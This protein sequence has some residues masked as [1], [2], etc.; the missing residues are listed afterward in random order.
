[1]SRNTK[2]R[3]HSLSASKIF[4]S[5]GG[6]AAL[7]LML[8]NPANAVGGRV[9]DVGSSERINLSGQLATL[10][11]R[12]IASACNISA[13]VAVAESSAVLAISANQFERIND[14]LL[15]GNRGFGIL[16][17]E[18]RSKTLAAIDNVY[19]AWVPLQ[20]E[21]LAV[22]TGSSADQTIASLATQSAP[23]L[24]E[25]NILVAEITGQ[26]A[27]PVALLHADAMLI[28]IAGRQRMLSQ[29]MSKDVCLLASGVNAETAAEDLEQAMTLFDASLSALR[30]GMESVG[31]RPPP[32]E[33]IVEGLQF[34]ADEWS[35]VQPMISDVLAGGTLDA[36]ARKEAYN[37]FLG[38]EAR[39]NNVVF[40]YAKNSKLGL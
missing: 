40:M 12:V 10:S 8:A 14:A 33:Q 13:G 31:V 26:Y 30:N 28:D 11:E 21:A 9:A 3:K 17:E 24:E 18:S 16:G 4:K 22:E 5:A 38:M 25:A 39:M 1:M 2:Q 20:D 19:T 32:T 34:V 29:R 37:A 15:N 27:D 36:A 35:I 7:A 6:V 23:L